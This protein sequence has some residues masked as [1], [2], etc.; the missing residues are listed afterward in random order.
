MVFEWDEAKRQLLIA[1][2]KID[3]IDAAGIFEG[4]VVTRT[5][6]RRDYGEVRYISIGFVDG[7]CF[8]VV[9]TERDGVTRLITA[10]RGGRNEQLKYQ[11]GI[12]GRDK[13]DE[14]AR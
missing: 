8:V 1:A 6:N 5:D 2:R 9:H 13:G 14:G 12:T 10:W 11:A 7:Q 4:P 3:L